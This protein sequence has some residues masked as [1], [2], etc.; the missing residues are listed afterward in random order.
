[1]AG[2]QIGN[3]RFK[4]E[5][6]NLEM[7]IVILMRLAVVPLALLGIFL[8]G[9]ALDLSRNVIVMEAAMPVAVSTT[10]IAKR[11]HADARFTASATLF[12]TILSM[13]TLP[14]MAIL[15]LALQ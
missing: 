8:L 3:L 11:Y 1:V 5:E 12:S 4:R 7:G 2:A 9:G 14:L 15:I 10:I 6:L 13:I